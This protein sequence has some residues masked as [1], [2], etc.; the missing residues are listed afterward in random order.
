MPASPSAWS[1][2]AGSETAARPQELVA[3]YTAQRTHTAPEVGAGNHRH[4]GPHCTQA[5]QARMLEAGGACA[6]CCIPQFR[7][8]RWNVHAQQ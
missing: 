4:P 7:A 5:C 8:R 1:I 2:K 6:L 3:H